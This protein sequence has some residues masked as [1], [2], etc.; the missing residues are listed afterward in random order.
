MP[1]N[2]NTT[3]AALLAA[4]IGITALVPAA[5]AE[6]T[7]R[8][9][10]GH[11]QGARDQRHGDLRSDQRGG[12]RG[13]LI[14]LVCAPNGAE[15]LEI[16]LVRLSHRVELT[17]EQT[18]LFEALKTA[19]LTAQTGYAD[20]CASIRPAAGQ[21]SAETPS[22]VDR[23]ATR[24]KLDEAR[25]AA[26]TGVLPALEAFYNSLT[27]AQKASIDMPRGGDR[28]DSRGPGMNAPADD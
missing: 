2:R 18:P 7:G 28:G 5:L 13:G 22:L 10:P 4:S 11:E 26:L 19:A 20:S 17:A 21:A 8:R 3:F 23:F 9:G 12:F 27:D 25:V 1:T 6:E 16:G 14:D 24:L 15:R